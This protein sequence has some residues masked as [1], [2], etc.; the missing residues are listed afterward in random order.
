M[1]LASAFIYV[2]IRIG[3]HLVAYGEDPALFDAVLSSLR[4]TM[5]IPN[6]DGSHPKTIS[7][8]LDKKPSRK[9]A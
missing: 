2:C 8:D 1:S 4:N 5:P 3:C 9:I 7:L 6:A